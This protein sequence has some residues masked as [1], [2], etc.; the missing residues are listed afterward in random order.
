[1]GYA[2]NFINAMSIARHMGIGMP[3]PA[4]EKRTSFFYNWMPKDYEAELVKIKAKTSDLSR[5]RREYVIAWLNDFKEQKYE[6]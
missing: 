4:N 5:I 1:M 6:G 3:V 2:Q